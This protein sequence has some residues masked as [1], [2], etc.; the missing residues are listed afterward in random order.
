MPADFDACVK[1]GGRVRTKDIGKDK[2]IHICFP[3]GG[4]SSIAGEVKIKQ[5]K[6]SHAPTGRVYKG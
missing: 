5:S 6:D 1:G 4:G 2:Y 3:K